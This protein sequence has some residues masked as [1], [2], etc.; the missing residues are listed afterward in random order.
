MKLNEYQERAVNHLDGPCIVT[1]C[2]G[3]GKTF[4]LVERILKLIERGVRPQNILCI[5]F[6]NKAA[7]EM[8][9]RICKRLNIK[10]PNFFIGTFHSLCANILR[11]MG[12]LAGYPSN[13]TILDDKDQI[14][15]I[16]QVSRQM[17]FDINKIDAQSISNAMNHFRDQLEEDSWLEER[18][19]NVVFEKIARGYFQRCK[20]SSLV[21]FSGLIFDTIKMIEG[22]EEIRTKLQTGFKYILV[23]ETQDTNGSQYHLVNLLG[24]KWKNIMLIGDQDQCVVEG[25]FVK[26]NNGEKRIEE[27]KI[28]DVV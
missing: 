10:K 27:I 21:D 7:N 5:T 18:L 2:P 19:T 6:T 23:D 25:E 22:C 12:R 26:T 28:G 8:K 11:K 16:M 15:L 17:N 9:E 3:S 14:D 13:F 1:S 24:D 20:T 4:V